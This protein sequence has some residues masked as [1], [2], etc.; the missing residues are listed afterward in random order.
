MRKRSIAEYTQPEFDALRQRL[1]TARDVLHAAGNSLQA[2]ARAYYVVYATGSFAA[3]KHAVKATHWRERH[4]V[5]DQAF[6]H[7]ELGDVVYALYCG[8]KRGH[9]L[10][11]GGSPGIDS[12]L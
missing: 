8:G 10:D 5:T 1:K 12:R 11:P 7:S 2:V 4:R 6:S 9:I 3:G